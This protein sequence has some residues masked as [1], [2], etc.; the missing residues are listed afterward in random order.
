MTDY[1]SDI[2]QCNYSRREEGEKG[3]HV[4]VRNGLDREHRDEVGTW[5]LGVRRILRLFACQT[6][7]KNRLKG[8]EM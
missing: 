3:N 1:T 7:P 8:E 5:C 6:W 2:S 4:H